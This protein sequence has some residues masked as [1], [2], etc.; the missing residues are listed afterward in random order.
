MMTKTMQKCAPNQKILKTHILP[1]QSDFKGKIVFIFSDPDKAAESAL[2]FT[3]TDETFWSLH[4]KHL[5]SSDHAWRDKVGGPANQTVNQNLLSYDALGCHKQLLQWLHQKTTPCEPKDAQVLAIKYENL[6]DKETLVA[7]QSFLSSN[8]QLPARYE[9][10]CPKEKQDHREITF[11]ATHNQGTPEHPKYPAY[12]EAR[13]LW[14]AAPSL[15]Y[16]KLN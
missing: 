15:S 13:K 12:N 3:L 7:L 16:Y 5:E 2:H 9:R 4:F 11:R 14:E 6:W 1:P 10:G 8:I